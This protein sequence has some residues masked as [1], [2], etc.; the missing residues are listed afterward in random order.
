MEAKSITQLSLWFGITEYDIFHGAYVW[1]YSRG[2]AGA[3]DRY[4]ADFHQKDIIPAFVC[5]YLMRVIFPRLIIK[6][7]CY[8]G[9]P[10]PK[11][12]NQNRF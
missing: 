9:K 2:E 1:R 8:E 10:E 12:V 4:V 11:W 6:G 3:V 5:A 7:G